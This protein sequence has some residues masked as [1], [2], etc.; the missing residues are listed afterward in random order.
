MVGGR[1]E[2][3][4]EGS[5]YLEWWNAGKRY[6]EPVGPNAFVAAEK[7]RLKQAELVAVHNGSIPASVG[8]VPRAQDSGTG[9][10]LIQRIRAAHFR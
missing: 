6:W 8:E 5:Y 4:P 2:V 7:M 9:A 3:H 1:D 10:R